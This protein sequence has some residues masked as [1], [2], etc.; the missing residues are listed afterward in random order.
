MNEFMYEREIAAYKYEVAQ[1][2]SQLEEAEASAN[3]WFEVAMRAEGVHEC[4]YF[5]CSE[6]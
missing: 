2:V 4:K 6:A 3:R 1:L 5:S